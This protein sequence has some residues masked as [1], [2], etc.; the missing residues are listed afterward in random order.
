MVLHRPDERSSRVSINDSRPIEKD[1]TMEHLERVA[2]FKK[3]AGG[4]VNQILKTLDLLKKTANR[5]NYAYTPDQIDKMFERIRRD[6]DAAE[7]AFRVEKKRGPDW[8]EL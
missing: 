3:R 8:F 5:D 2:R 1:L 4:R 7:Q 6:V